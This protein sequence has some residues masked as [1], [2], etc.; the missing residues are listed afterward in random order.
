MSARKTLQD[1]ADVGLSRQTTLVGTHRLGPGSS[2]GT[3]IVLASE[4]RRACW[5]LASVDIPTFYLCC[6]W[7]PTTAERFLPRDSEIIC[8]RR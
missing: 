4:G 1:S 2:S 3:E 5:I 7:R 6:K 8:L